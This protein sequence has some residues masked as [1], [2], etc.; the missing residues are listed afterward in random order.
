MLAWVRTVSLEVFQVPLRPILLLLTRPPATQM[1]LRALTQSS[2]SCNNYRGGEVTS[3]QPAPIQQM[4][5]HRTHPHLT[6]YSTTWVTN[7]N[8][9]VQPSR[10]QTAP[11]CGT[12]LPLHHQ[13]NHQLCQR[14]QP[15]LCGDLNLPIVLPHLLVHNHL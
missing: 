3:P 1:R 6:H 8:I 13:N 12:C 11:V 14:Q 2:P 7:S 4:K 5:L 9:K 15:P 10:G